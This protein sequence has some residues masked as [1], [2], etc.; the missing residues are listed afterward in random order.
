MKYMKY[1]TRAAFGR[2]A[3][4]EARGRYTRLELL[5]DSRVVQ[6]V[7]GL[8]QSAARR[9]NRRGDR[10]E[11][12][13]RPQSRL[14]GPPTDGPPAQRRSMRMGLTDGLVPVDLPVDVIVVL[15]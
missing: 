6:H 5:G 15:E 12:E 9:S 13:L 7:R 2:F 1:K 8:A 14:A 3:V 4:V 11:A 10:R